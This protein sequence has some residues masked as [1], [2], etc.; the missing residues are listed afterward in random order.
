M[1]ELKRE[2]D[3]RFRIADKIYQDCLYDIEL[4]DIDSISISEF[5][6]ELD[7]VDTEE[8]IPELPKSKPEPVI[9]SVSKAK[10]VE[11]GLK[12][13][14]SIKTDNS[15]IIVQ[16]V[17]TSDCADERFEQ[18]DYA[19]PNVQVESDYEIE[20]IAIDAVIDFKNM[21]LSVQDFFLLSVEDKAAIWDVTKYDSL[22]AFEAYRKV[23]DSAQVSKSVSDLYDEFIRIKNKC[24]EYKKEPWEREYRK[25]ILK[26]E[27][28]NDKRL[29]RTKVR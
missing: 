14:R 23:A 1:K 7:N 17:V 26:G 19:S 27:Y 8:K 22:D 9:E 18:I 28:N 2:E 24:L 21:N 13:S 29:I 15:I 20:I 6:K 25:I 16:N 12:D 3:K 4:K 5:E 11:S 10:V